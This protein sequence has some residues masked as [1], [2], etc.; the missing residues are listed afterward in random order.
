MTHP[1]GTADCGRFDPA[2]ATPKRPVHATAPGRIVPASDCNLGARGCTPDSTASGSPDPIGSKSGADTPAI[3]GA[4]RGAH[5]ILD[6][7]RHTRFRWATED[8]LQR[9]L[10]QALAESG[11]QVE[12]EVRLN[13]RD[14]ID[15]LV[16]RVGIEV[17]IDGPWRTVERQLDRYLE[18]ELLDA[19][20]LVTAKAMHQRI[21]PRPRLWIHQLSRSG[22]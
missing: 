12:R 9:G 17:K 5:E 18:C 10:T 11:F 15:L 20:V 8:E 13:A 14:R 21:A 3:S 16:G 4:G 1:I 19:V 6:V 22:L 7:L 2:P